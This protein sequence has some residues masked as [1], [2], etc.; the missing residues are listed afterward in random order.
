M[1]SGLVGYVDGPV[2]PNGIMPSLVDWILLVYKLVK[3]VVRGA[4]I[5]R[6]VVYSCLHSKETTAFLHFNEV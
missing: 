4:S 5:C 1:Q 2:R 6:A 3:C